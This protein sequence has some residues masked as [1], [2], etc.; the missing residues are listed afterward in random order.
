MAFKDG[1]GLRKVWVTVD[2]RRVATAEYGIPNAG[3][4]NYWRFSND[5]LHPDIGFRAQVDM[6]NMPAGRHWLGLW[7]VG[8]DGSVEPWSEIPIDLQ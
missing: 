4:K 2:G 5:P 6:R 7:L 8:R 3:P 1:V